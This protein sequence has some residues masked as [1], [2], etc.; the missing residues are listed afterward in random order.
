[1]GCPFAFATW[2]EMHSASGRSPGEPKPVRGSTYPYPAYLIE[3]GFLPSR[4]DFAG[5][6]PQGRM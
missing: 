2:R 1:M 4:R 6:E 3:S 5:Q